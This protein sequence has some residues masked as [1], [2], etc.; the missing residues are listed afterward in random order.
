MSVH[1]DTVETRVVPAPSDA[2]EPDGAG[3]P[4]PG[5]AAEEWS[6]HLRLA[7]RDG[8]RTAARDFDD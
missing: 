5:A 6:A 7:R 3:G 1:V 4:R 8:C 2:E